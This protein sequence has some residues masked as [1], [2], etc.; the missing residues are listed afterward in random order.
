MARPEGWPALFWSAFKGS[1]NAMVL[2]DERRR[3]VEVNG[4][5]VE[6]LGYPRDELIG[7]PVY[8]FVEGGPL[9]TAGEWRATIA[10]RSSAA[11]PASCA[12]TGTP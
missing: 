7:R 6:L 4:A 10:L 3:H 8:E 1:R 5:Y 11:R 12:R 9:L 2:L